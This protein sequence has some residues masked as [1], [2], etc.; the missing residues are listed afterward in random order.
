MEPIQVLICDDHP[1]FRHSL[2]TLLETAADLDVVGEAGDGEE[3]VQVA[4]AVQPDVILMDLNMPGV[5]GVE[6]T[7]RVLSS[8]PHIGVVVLTMV[9]DDDSVCLPRCRPEPGDTF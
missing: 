2:R 8:S 6:A 5:N 1:D 3:A 9:E 4:A 7:R